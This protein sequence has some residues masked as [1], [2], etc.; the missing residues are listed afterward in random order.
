MRAHAFDRREVAGAS[1]A[2]F[3]LDE[4]PVARCQLYPAPA[5]GTPWTTRSR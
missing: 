2:V 5:Q 1:N 3:V 4:P